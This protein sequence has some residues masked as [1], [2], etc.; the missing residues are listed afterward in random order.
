M[1][2]KVAKKGSTKPQVEGLF[3]HRPSGQYFAYIGYHE[4]T[5]IEPKTRRRI[6]RRVR[7]TCYFGT[8]RAEAVAKF[9]QMKGEWQR[10]IAAE[11][12][13]YEEEK[14]WKSANDLPPPGRFKPC[15]PKEGRDHQA[16]RTWADKIQRFSASIEKEKK[17]DSL[18]LT[19]R[20][21]R[22]RYLADCRGRI[23]LQAGKGINQNS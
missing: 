11:R 1:P 10:V 19:I 9:Y 22:E 6:E 20:E 15:W 8:D 13:Q 16:V 12:K 23:G 7:T 21:A 4:K 2:Q 18:N 3:Y 14:A 5:E 17:E